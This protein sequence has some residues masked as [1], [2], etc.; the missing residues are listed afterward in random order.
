[1]IRSNLDSIRQFLLG[2]ARIA[3]DSSGKGIIWLAAG[4][5][6]FDEAMVKA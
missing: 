2:L 3:T 4:L 6:V 5:V 1:M